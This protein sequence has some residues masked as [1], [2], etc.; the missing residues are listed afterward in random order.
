MGHDP[1]LAL[2]IRK[3]P[4]I[5]QY[6]DLYLTTLFIIINFTH[7]TLYIFFLFSKNKKKKFKKYK[8]KNSMDV[9]T[10]YF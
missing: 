6:N 5:F 9:F 3:K 8:K 4:I 7:F 1:S 10:L 2:F